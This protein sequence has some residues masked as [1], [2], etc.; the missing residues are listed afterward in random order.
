MYV[1]EGYQ[2]Q[3]VGINLINTTLE[4]A[5]AIKELEHVELGVL[6]TS[7]AASRL[8]KKAGFEEFGFQKNYFKAEN[9]YVDQKLMFISKEKFQQ[10]N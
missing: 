4:K 5:F 8:Y 7:P 1:K 9:E 2:G 6:S 10:E 3:H